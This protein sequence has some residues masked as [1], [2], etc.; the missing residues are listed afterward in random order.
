[1]IL[2]PIGTIHSPYKNSSEAPFQ[3]R[4]SRE[5]S[6]VEIYGEFADGLK[7]VE[8][9]SHLFMLYWCGQADRVKLQTHTP[10]GTEIRGVFAC[11]SPSRPN[12][13][14]ICIVEL[15]KREG[16]FLHVQGL[17][18]LDGSYLLDIKPFY[19]DLDCV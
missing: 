1:M 15:L 8:Q 14:A 5:I 18:A 19:P 13:I 4:F 10:H 3:G 12:P 6:V 7:D 11:R 16:N 2:K 17:D 9:S